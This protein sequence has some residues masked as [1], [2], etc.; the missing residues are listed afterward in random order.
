M[1]SLV[2]LIIAAFI[3]ISEEVAVMSI[4]IGSEWMKVAIVSVGD[5]K[6]IYN[7]TC[8]YV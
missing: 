5:M 2:L 7:D 3:G 1:A 4:D 8:Q 6:S